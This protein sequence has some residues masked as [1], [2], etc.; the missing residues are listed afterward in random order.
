M[1]LQDVTHKLAN[2]QNR[3]NLN[4]LLK[5]VMI[6]TG[7]ERPGNCPNRYLCELSVKK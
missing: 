1:K 6:A 2:A 4:G 3:V 7:C 5:P